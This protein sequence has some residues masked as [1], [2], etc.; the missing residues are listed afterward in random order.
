VPDISPACGGLGGGI[1]DMGELETPAW[2]LVPQGLFCITLTWEG[3]VSTEKFTLLQ[4]YKA[5]ESE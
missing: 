1:A 3:F 2:G 4:A 5:E